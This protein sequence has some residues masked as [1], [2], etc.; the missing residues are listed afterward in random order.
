MAKHVT[1]LIFAQLEPKNQQ[2]RNYYWKA[3]VKAMGDNAVKAIV[4][5]AKQ[6]DDK[7]VFKPMHTGNLS[8][9]QKRN[10][11]ESITMVTKK[12]CGKVKGQTCANG[13][14]Q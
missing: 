2:K 3:G 10:A 9:E 14:K 13:R 6:L 1:G 12:R 8:K 7:E 11:L 5:D 4:K